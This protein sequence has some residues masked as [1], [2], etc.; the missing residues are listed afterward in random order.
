MW[1]FSELPYERADV[2]KFI[3]EGMQLIETFE[4]APTAEAAIAA[5]Y[6]MDEAMQR[7]ATAVTVSHIRYDINTNDPV[8][9]AEQNYY[10]QNLSKTMVLNVRQLHAMVNHPFRKELEAA[11]GKIIFTQADAQI[12]LADE[13]LIPG[14]TEEQMLKS[15]YSK[16]TAGCTTEYRGETCNFYALL[17][18]MQDPDR[19]V[20]EGAF[21]K[22][23]EMYAGIADELDEIY[24]KMVAIRTEQAKLIGYENYIPFAYLNPRC[25]SCRVPEATE[26]RQ[27]TS[28]N[29]ASADSFHVGHSRRTDGLR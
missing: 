22:W 2:D 28:V 6:A 21:R 23:A 11:L 4:K 12:K 5:Y 27:G 9:E 24:D 15:R 19:S 14:M 29:A 7:F 18:F 16:L 3:A 13:R 20:R 25:E 1:T 26:P 10:D 8:Y 17:K